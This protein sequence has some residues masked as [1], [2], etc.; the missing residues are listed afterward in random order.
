MGETLMMTNEKS[1]Y[2][3][4]D[5]STFMAFKGNLT[6]IP[7]VEGTKDLL[8]VYVAIAENPKKHPGVNCEMAN[9]FINF[10]VSEEGQKLI[11]S[12]GM[13]KYGKALFFKAEGN[14]TLIGCSSGECAVPTNASCAAA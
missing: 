9:T 8:N 11:G 7:L 3:L 10:L 5:T 14:C 13:D 2:T 12:Y 4:T 6:L 1:A